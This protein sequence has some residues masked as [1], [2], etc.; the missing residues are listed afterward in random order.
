MSIGNYWFRPDGSEF[1]VNNA[2]ASVVGA[3][4]DGVNIT[5]LDN[6]NI[7]AV[8]D[9]A[10]A[11]SSIHAQIL[12]PEGTPVGDSFQI[13]QPSLVPGGGELPHWSPTVTPTAAGGFFVAWVV[14]EY[15]GGYNTGRNVLGRTYDA[16][17]TA[18]NDQFV[19]ANQVS[20]SG[21][22]VT[23]SWETYPSLDTLSDGR[24]V[25]AFYD[26]LDITVKVLSADGTSTLQNTH[27]NTSSTTLWQR[28][29]SVA[30][31][32][33]GGFV[34]SWSDD[35]EDEGGHGVYAQIYDATGAAVGGNFRVNSDS[36]GVQNSPVAVGLAGGGFAI[37][38][39]D[40]WA[41]HIPDSWN[42]VAVRV[43]DAAGNPLGA[44]IH[45]DPHLGDGQGGAYDIGMEA[46]PDGGFM[47]LRT[48]HVDYHDVRNDIYGTRYDAAGNQMGDSFLINSFQTYHQ[49][50]PRVVALEDG[51][52]ATVWYDWGST[53]RANGLY[54]QV[55]DVAQLGG[56]PTEEDDVIVFDDS[57]HDV[58]LLG[59][60][61]QALGGTEDDT[62]R[63]GAGNDRLGGAGGNDNLIGDAGNDTLEG[64]DGDDMLRG[65]AGDDLM[66]GGDGADEYV[67][68]PGGGAD[69]ITDFD[70]SQDRLS[71]DGVD[72]GAATGANVDGNR[73]ITFEDGATLTLVGFGANNAPTGRPAITGTARQGESLGVD[74]TS[75][76]DADGFD[77][78][79]V[80]IQWLRDGTELPGATGA[81]YA[82]G[83]EDVGSRISVRITYVDGF[84]IEESMTSAITSAIENVNDAPTGEVAISGIAAQ[85]ETLTADA[86]TVADVDGFDPAAASG[87]WLRDG[88]A[89]SGATAN[90]YTLTQADVGAEISFAYSYTDGFGFRE[91]V[92]S[93][94][95]DAVENVNDAPTGDVVISGTAKQG[96]TLTADASGVADADGIVDGSQSYQWLRDGT[97]IPGATAASYLL[98]AADVGATVSVRFSYGDGQGTVESLTAVGAGTVEPDHL[99]LTGTPEADVLVGGPGDDTIL[100]LDGNDRL[101]GEA[102]NDSMDGGLGADTLNGGD[103]D[104]IIIGGPSEGD[105]RDVIFAG[106]GNDSVDAG[107]GNDQVF[108]QGGN[109]TIAGGAGVDEIQGQDGDDVITGSAFS[110]LVFGGAGNDFVNGG[111]GH[112]RIN[113]GTGADKF[114]HVGVEGHGSDWV[115]DYSSA[116]GDVLLFGNTTAT[117]ADFQVNFAH[118][119]N[120]EGERAGDDAVQEAFVIYRPT[121]QI[122][123]ALVDGQGQSAINLQIGSEV[124]D[125]LA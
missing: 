30:A 55:F 83:Q 16:S 40:S 72:T 103:G 8:W 82:L 104:D 29:P 91:T 4:S 89:I 57:G 112:D 23:S 123:W 46:L 63:G 73:V 18:L 60:N 5:V 3:F 9:D 47:I 21:W 115:Q 88:T 14:E 6:G 28:D 116:E 124:F 100:G 25:M 61:D 13:S 2:R 79:D 36:T 102:G 39:A 32:S 50:K 78:A 96:E 97:V 62:F 76:A 31:L 54:G 71:F 65:G 107:A 45:A 106:E 85:G 58:D 108:G 27:V 70:R 105:L 84:F 35:L 74:L 117:R 44:D 49:S 95:T 113:G 38:F 59:G 19:V 99:S 80:D 125:L 22:V 75:I 81:T 7:V 52:I 69:R 20:D 66:T 64:G 48:R 119:Q 67:I 90:T 92:T 98:T 41:E 77:P 42:H 34:V 86:S 1:A 110:D 11:P 87:Q 37:A 12:T 10:T 51:Q 17:G 114:F 93:A 120:A 118:T 111:F 56:T 109:D 15:N 68:E 122:M 24:I 94:A 26:D 43:Y 33:G 53:D 121:G 101:L